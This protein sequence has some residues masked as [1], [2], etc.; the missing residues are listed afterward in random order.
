MKIQL[1]SFRENANSK[2]KFDLT[3]KLFNESDAE[4]IL[5]PG[6]TIDKA[7][8]LEKLA[9]KLNNKKTTAFLELTEL[10]NR[11]IKNWAF[12]IENN[13]LIN[14]YTHQLFASS[15]EVKD[16]PYLVETL[17]NEIKNNRIHKVKSKKICLLLCGELNMLTNLQTE[18]NKV[19]YRTDSAALAKGFKTMFKNVDVVL[20]PM[21]S[22]MGNQGKMHKRR[23]FLSTRDRAYF[24]TANLD[25]KG[26]S[27]EESFRTT[28]ALQYGY[29]NGKPIEPMNEIA[30]A[31][32]IMREFEI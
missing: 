18:R 2:V 17:Y 11:G 16:N 26:K 13:K 20:N 7:S 22:P 15:D 10:G 8:E 30:T 21:H 5:F 19:M 1:V 27:Y 23:I 4:L 28:K 24:S 9:T 29:Y 12:K 14:C 6:H 32:Y 25:K 31:D 3:L